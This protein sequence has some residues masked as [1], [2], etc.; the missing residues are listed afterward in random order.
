MT[1]KLMI[2]GASLLLLSG[3]AKSYL[4]V[5]SKDTATLMLIP[6]SK[7]I[8]FKDDFS[9][10]I[11]DYK[12]LLTQQG[13]IDNDIDGNYWSVPLHTEVYAKG[14]GQKGDSY[15]G[16]LKTDSDTVSKSIKIQA[17]KP[18]RLLTSY[19]DTSGNNIK[20]EY[21]DWIFIP[22]KNKQYAIIY[23]KKKLSLFR[24]ASDFKIVE[25]RGNHFSRVPSSR[26][27]NFNITKACKKYVKNK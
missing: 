27:K 16:E 7:T 10:D 4:D 2:M 17:R 23:T 22:E 6:K 9:V 18:L 15:L 13:C 1:K 19:I 11:Y 21:A 26:I 12:K 14:N 24:S 3:C 25:K 5:K 20:V 8:L